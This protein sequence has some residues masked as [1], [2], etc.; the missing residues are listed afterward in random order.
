VES[1]LTAD[2]VARLAT[3]H[4]LDLPISSGVRAVLHGEVTPSEGLKMLMSREQKPEYPKGLF[5]P[6]A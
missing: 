5:T 2:E 4:G 1:V 3:K 6:L